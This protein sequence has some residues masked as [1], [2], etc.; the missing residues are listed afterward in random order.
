MFEGLDEGWR[1]RHCRD[2]G[3][4]QDDFGCFVDHQ[5]DDQQ[6][7]RV[8]EQKSGEKGLPKGRDTL[9]SVAGGLAGV[10]KDPD[11]VVRIVELK[12]DLPA[13][14]GGDQSDLMSVMGGDQPASVLIEAA[15]QDRR[16]GV[17]LM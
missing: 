6:F 9:T 14:G 13:F 8:P 2:L 15:E 5:S 3:V 17:T 11:A 4:E 10:I 12:A 16:I 1:V 7:G